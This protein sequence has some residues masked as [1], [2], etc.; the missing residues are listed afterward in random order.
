MKDLLKLFSIQSNA[1][2][3]RRMRSYVCKQLTGMGLAYSVDTHGNIITHK[4]AGVRPFVVC[5]IDTVHDFVKHFEI[6]LQT[7]KRGTFLYGWDSANVRQVGCGGDDKAGIWACLTA[8]RKLDNVSAVFFSREEVGCVGSKNIALDVFNDASMILQADRKGASDFI[9]YSNGVELYGDEFRAAALPI[10]KLYG[11]NEARGLCTD[12]GE[13]CARAVGVACVNLSAGYYNAHT[14]NEVQCVEELENVCALIIALCR[15]IG[16]E[17]HAYK[18]APVFLPS[19]SRGSY[20]DW[21]M[22]I[23]DAPNVD[24]RA[25]ILPHTAP[26][27][28]CYGVVG[29]NEIVPNVCAGCYD[30]HVN[31]GHFSHLEFVKLCQEL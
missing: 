10:A 23:W 4:G 22:D 3:E 15:N 29:A 30:E 8:L 21:D 9:C 28:L 12:A 17:V 26:C 27:A 6:R 20:W 1:R 14:D 19:Y 13:L 16:A 7:N 18:P 24:R 5:H 25:P 11:Y 2:D 31:S